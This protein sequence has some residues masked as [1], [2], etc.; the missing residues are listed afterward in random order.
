MC[1]KLS[2]NI[3]ISHLTLLGKCRINASCTTKKY[4]KNLNYPSSTHFH[5]YFFST[6]LILEGNDCY[7]TKLVKYVFIFAHVKIYTHKTKEI[8]FFNY[9][10]E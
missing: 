9:Q 8:Q 7:C 5:F 2:C 4:R 3:D 10:G 6:K 1:A